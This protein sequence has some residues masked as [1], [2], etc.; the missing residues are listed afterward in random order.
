MNSA[1]AAVVASEDSVSRAS[2]TWWCAAGLALGAAFCSKYTSA[3]VPLAALVALLSRRDLRLRLRE[4]GP[5]LA[6]AI[7]LIVFLPVVLWNARHDWVSF[8]FDFFIFLS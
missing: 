4:P 6:A 1:Q 3:L 8:A 2:L 5:Y 7:A